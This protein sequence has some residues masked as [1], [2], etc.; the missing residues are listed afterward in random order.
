MTREQEYLLMLLRDYLHMRASE[1]DVTIHEQELKKIARSQQLSAIVY[2]QTKSELLK[3]DYYQQIIRNKRI[4]NEVC[5]LRGIMKGIEY[6]FLKGVCIKDF[7]P[8]PVLRSMG[9]IDVLIRPESRLKVHNRLLENGYAF[10]NKWK[11]QWTYK[12]NGILLEVHD[13]A[14][15][16]RE[17]DDAREKFASDLWDY[18]E[19]NELDWNFHFFYVLFHLRR[20]LISRGVGFR[21]FMDVAVLCEREEKLDWPWILKKAEHLN[22]L[23]FMEKIFSFNEKTF[24]IKSPMPVFYYSIDARY[25]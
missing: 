23:E 18:V 12:K 2:S 5:I 8:M 4:D 25:L 20:H 11:E 10:C 9:D 21:Q 3:A 19:N 14:I 16:C 22:I 15:L 1:V 24:D 13:C 6:C 7:Y 17:A